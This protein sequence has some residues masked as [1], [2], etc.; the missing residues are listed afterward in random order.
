M[1][2]FVLQF[3]T[4]LLAAFNQVLTA[5]IVVTAFSLLLYSLTFNLHHRVA[6][7]FSGVLGALSAVFL[8]DVLASL[9]GQL[10]SA[11]IW[12]RF[13]WL[14]IAFLP[15]AYLHLSDALLETTGLPSRGRRRLA[16][17][18]GY[19]LA[20]S[21]FAMAAFTNWLVTDTVIEAGTQHLRPGPLF[22][23][24]TLLFAIGSA[25]A[26]VN[27]YRAYLR[28]PTSDTRRR[29][30][31]LLVAS[32]TLPL[33]VFPYLLVV[34]GQSAVLH[35]FVF[36]LASVSANLIIGA[37]LTVLAYAVAFFGTTQPDRV[38]KSRLFQWLLRGPFVASVVLMVLVLMNR[39]A[40][41]LGIEGSQLVPIA[42]IGSLLLLQFGITLV[43]IPLERWLFYGGSADRADVRRLQLLK[44][45]LLTASDTAQ[46]LESVVA[47]VCD[48]LRVP[49]A[50][51]AS[52]SE[53]GARIEAKVGPDTPPD[54]SADLSLA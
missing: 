49:S 30:R 33:S 31:Y 5:A 10:S 9:A 39:G 25:I 12:L 1:F 18:V 14:G 20:A 47:A 45:R 6:R 36:W 28:C 52:V 54:E 40:R 21:L 4:N 11:E 34:A 38:I 46:Y 23:A 22:A 16:I 2:S 53:E 19:A 3:L 48:L 35:P 37:M 24:F 17:R 13:Q 8:G 51:V 41:F 50:F 32:I 7:S 29:M 43:R 26:W 15:P 42:L 44:E 27:V